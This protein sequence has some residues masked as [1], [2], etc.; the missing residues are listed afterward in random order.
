[1]VWTGRW[2][3]LR[4]SATAAG[5]GSVWNVS[6]TPFAFVPLIGS[7]SGPT[8]SIATDLPGWASRSSD[9][10]S[11]F[12][13]PTTSAITACAVGI[14][15]GQGV[16]ELFAGRDS[17]RSSRI[18]RRADRLAQLIANGDRSLDRAEPRPRS[19]LA[20]RA[21]TVSFE[22][23]REACVFTDVRVVS[24]RIVVNRANGRAC[25]F[26]CQWLSHG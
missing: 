19:G 22:A 13:S 3:G 7:L 2:H 5:P 4:T 23:L 21:G 1:M 6:P 17:P 20:R 10:D 25:L 14:T 8:T 11:A 16:E 24:K 26:S 9:I 15:L 12:R 18:P